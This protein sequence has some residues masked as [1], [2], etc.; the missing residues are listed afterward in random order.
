MKLIKVKGYVTGIT[1]QPRDMVL[2]VDHIVG[3][4]G[5]TFSDGSPYV[6]VDT[7]RCYGLAIVGTVDELIEKIN[8]TDWP[9]V[10]VKI[11][12]R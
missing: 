12:I 3:F 2:N 11:E 5:C 7:T 9:I 1:D 8:A 6:S 4:W 10:N